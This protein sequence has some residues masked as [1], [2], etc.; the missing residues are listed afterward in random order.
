MQEFLEIMEN[1][2]IPFQLSK[3]M[4]VIG[5]F[6]DLDDEDCYIWLRRYRDEAEKQIVYDRV[7][8]SDYWKEEIRPRISELLVREK[9]RVNMLSPTAASILQ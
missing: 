3:G 8:G 9:T 2:I 7:Y 4:L 6:L 5:S 1:T